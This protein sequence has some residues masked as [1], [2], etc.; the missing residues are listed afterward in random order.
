MTPSP[1][2]EHARPTLRK[3]RVAGHG[4]TLVELLTVCA[5]IG[6]L[7]LILFPVISTIRARSQSTKC[8]SNLRQIGVLAKM[9]SNDNQGNI[10]PMY[11]PSDD[12]NGLSKKHWTGLLA[13]YMDGDFDG[14]YYPSYDELPLFI[15]PAEPDI[16]GY[17]LNYFWLSPFTTEYG[18]GLRV[19]LVKQ[20]EV[21]DPTQTVFITDV[22]LDANDNWHP[23]VRPPTMWAG[24]QSGAPNQT[25]FRHPNDTANVLWFD[26]HVSSETGG[27]SF[28]QDAELWD[29]L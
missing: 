6:I 15:C 25:A 21:A 12:P 19:K 9:Y 17:G 24:W 7:M 13:P 2:R 23:Y 18:P 4:F 20:Y 27:T 26:G 10:L 29:T 28:T 3:P 11:Y 14:N 22:T 8:Q 16:F 1:T 5:C